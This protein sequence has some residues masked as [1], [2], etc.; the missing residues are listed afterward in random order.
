MTHSSI[1]VQ[2]QYPSRWILRCH[3][4]LEW[5]LVALLAILLFLKGVLAGLKTLQTDFP[6]YYVAARLIREHFRL[7]R[8]YD[9]IWF[10]R[11][12]DHFGIEHQIT[13]FLGLTPFSAFPLLPFAE[14]PAIAAKRLWILINLA[15]LVAAVCALRKIS[16]IGIRRAWLIALCAMIP[17]RT[18]FLL[19]QMHLVILALLVAAYICHM[20]GKQVAGGCFVAV[21]GAL[22]I[23]PLFFCLYFIAKRRWKALAA[24]LLCTASCV[25]LSYA[26]AGQATMNAYL[27]EQLTRTLQGESL[28]PFAPSTTS[29]AALFHRLFLFEPEQNPHPL[30]W[31]PLLYALL[32]PL[33]QALLTG[34]LLSRLRL[35]FRPDARESLEWSSFL[36]LLLFLSSAPATYHYVVMIAPAVIAIAALIKMQQRKSA[37]VF[38]ILYV[39]ACNLG[40]L[41]SGH[42]AVSLLTPLRYARLWAGVG[43][44]SLCC[45]ALA[46]DSAAKPVPGR[47]P[48]FG[49]FTSPSVRAAAIVLGLWAAGFTTAWSHV[50]HLCAECSQRVSLADSAWL[51]SAPVQTKAGLL[52]VAMNHEYRI[53]RDGKPLS[54]PGMDRSFASDQLSFTASQSGEDIWLELASGATSRVVRVAPENADRAACEIDDAESPALSPDGS[55]LAFLRE[56]RGIG[57]L[58]LFDPKSC[59]TGGKREDP[60]RI[61]SPALDVRATAAGPADSWLFSA[62]SQGRKKIYTVSR[63]HSPQ[64]LIDVK[65]DLDSPS[66][67]PAGKRIVVRK[68]IAGRWQLVTFDLS[69]E[70]QAHTGEQLT[71]GDCNAY[72][73]SW[74]DDTTVIYATDCA[75][76]MGLSTL[77]WL[78][79]NQRQHD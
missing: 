33:W 48:A 27:H 29:S 52:Y 11:A 39:V 1:A 68:E 15:L 62:V 18:S 42:A 44:L 36:T 16:G 76:G 3:V 38:L 2:Q 26:V 72:T 10:Q 53:L 63:D 51:R 31:S 20:R 55:Q 21:A 30:L 45:A 49:Y 4:A 60:V 73:P 35:E 28:S 71:F 24:T 17:L 78:N 8:I 19:G 43:L 65:T 40:T 50:K 9:W 66:V 32:Y 74:K 34:M 57:S 14:L 23:Y 59:D 58:W 61:T 64:L 79:A 5:A 69:P 25:A 12:A 22:K 56:E 54:E 67:A 47:Y 46:R 13:G 7:D 6:N 70:L 37:V 41:D 75:R 77:A